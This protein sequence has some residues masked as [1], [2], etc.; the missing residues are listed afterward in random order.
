MIDKWLTVKE[1]AELLLRSRGWIIQRAKEEGWPYRS[2]AVR[3]GKERRYHL[4]NLPEDVQAAYAV[5][6]KT[7]LEELRARL[8]PA[9]KPGK[10]IDIPRYS[11]RGARTGEIKNM[12]QFP[13]AY[14]E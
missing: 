8:K 13:Q 7:S 14:R 11:G 3:G 2:Y 12:D 6:I 10:K 4:A 9:S 5:S 1:I